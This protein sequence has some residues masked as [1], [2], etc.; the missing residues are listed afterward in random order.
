MIIMPAMLLR[1]LLLVFLLVVLLLVII[2]TALVIV[3]SRPFFRSARG[4]PL[5]L[6]PPLYGEARRCCPWRTRH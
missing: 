2:S 1:I 3:I 5:A 6:A 4:L